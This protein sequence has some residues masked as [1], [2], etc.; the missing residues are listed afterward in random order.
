MAVLEVG[1][2]LG[3]GFPREGASGQMAAATGA[4]VRLSAP[5]EHACY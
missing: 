4:Q 1:V 5:P 3:E 2:R